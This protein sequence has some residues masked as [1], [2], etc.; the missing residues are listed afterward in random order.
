MLMMTLLIAAILVSGYI[1]MSSVQANH[2]NRAAVAMFTGV[3]VWWIYML[4]GQEFLQLMHPEEYATYLKEQQADGVSVPGFVAGNVLQR[5]INEACSVILFLIS[6]NTILE[7]LNN[8]GVFDSLITWLRMRNSRRFLWILTLITFAISANVDN[9][10]T[11]VLMMTIM[12]KIVSS[13]RQRVVYSC[14]IFVAA[15]LGGAFTVI[16]DM[17]SL[18]LWV[19]GVVTPSAFA[20]ALVLPCLVSLIVFNIL[21]SKMLVGNVEVNSYLNGYRGDDSVL[22]PWQK[23]VLLVVGIA[24]LWAIPT[25]AAITHFPPFLGALCVLALVW[26][27]ESAFTFRMNGNLLFV[28]RSYLRNSEFIGIQIILYYLGIS[29][30]IGALK[31]SGA[32]DA[33][34]RWLITNV[35]NVYLYGGIV[36]I[37]SSLVDNVPMVMAGM[38]MFSVETAGPRLAEFGVDGAYW[39]MLAYCSAIGSCLFFV[40]TL[41]GNAAVAI[42]NIRVSWYARHIIWRMLLA[43]GAG[44]LVFWLMH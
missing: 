41:A 29:L 3:T 31:E 15:N 25:F 21:L 38:N 24:G 16:G 44:L 26:L 17:T 35:D 9:L 14:A 12:S 1:L 7:L 28:R 18:M 23:S 6:T 10:T 30:G 32:L 13:H 42:E 11:V 43:W 27:L 34:G 19:R 39:Q 37:L 40:S 20:G 8:N 5:Y 33:A 4:N 22:R 2:V 36:G